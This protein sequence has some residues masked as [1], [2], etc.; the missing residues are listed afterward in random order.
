VLPNDVSTAS[1]A[2]WKRWDARPEVTEFVNMPGD[3]RL[4]DKAEEEE[5]APAAPRKRVENYE[6]GEE[7]AGWMAADETKVQSRRTLVPGFYV[8]D[9]DTPIPVAAPQPKSRRK[10]RSKAKNKDKDKDKDK[11]KAGDKG[12]S[13]SS[14]GGIPDGLDERLLSELDIVID[15]SNSPSRVEAGRGLTPAQLA[16]L[17]ELVTQIQELVRGYDTRDVGCFM[18]YFLIVLF[19]LTL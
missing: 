4:V 3:E 18:I 13:S 17:E 6:T 5:E 11:D 7:F 10:P 15:A 1:I 12:K 9:G 8:L 14:A 16:E 19:F 2:E